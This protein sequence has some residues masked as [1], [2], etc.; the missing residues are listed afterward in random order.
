MKLKEYQKEAIKYIREHK[1]AMLNMGCR[2]GKTITALCAMPYRFLWVVGPPAVESFWRKENRKL[3][4]PK[5]LCFL[6]KFNKKDLWGMA[7][8]KPRQ[9]IVDESHENMKWQTSEPILRACKR[10]EYVALLTATPIINDP[11]SLYW[12]L[13]ICGEFMGT[14]DAF[15]LIYLSL[16]H[17]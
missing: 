15:K 5:D 16:I 14:I 9:I 6:S 8:A 7:R 12:P 17:I 11:L 3:K 10:A 4:R 2:T 1:K 13:K